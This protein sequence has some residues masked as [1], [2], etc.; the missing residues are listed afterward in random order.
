MNPL[1]SALAASAACGRL[2]LLLFRLRPLHG[3][4]SSDTPRQHAKRPFVP[5]Q[6]P[7]NRPPPQCA[8]PKRKASAFYQD[9]PGR[10]GGPPRAPSPGECAKPPCISSTSVLCTAA[11]TRYALPKRK[12]S[13][14]YHGIPVEPEALS[15]QESPP[16]GCAKPPC[17]SSTS[18]LCTAA[19]HPIRP[20]KT[21]SVRFLSEHS[22][23]SR[24]L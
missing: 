5:L 13:A 21:Q 2:S 19:A 12:A 15:R 24:R 11:F 14:F 1:S 20:A 7:R 4:L 17:I 3:G 22:R 9:A 6:S 10:A 8:L 16:G 23:Q 18:V